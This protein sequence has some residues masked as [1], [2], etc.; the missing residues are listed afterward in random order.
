MELNCEKCIKQDVCAIKRHAE[1]A[2][3][4]FEKNFSTQ[5]A[6]NH[7][8]EFSISCTHFVEQK[9]LRGEE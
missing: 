4:T 6:R 9:I 8:I 7:G 3:E 2:I 5:F 1:S